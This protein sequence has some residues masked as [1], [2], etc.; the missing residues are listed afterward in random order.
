RPHKESRPK[1]LSPGSTRDQPRAFSG[2]GG[3]VTEDAIHLSFGD[4][5]THL[6]HRI[7]A[8]ADLQILHGVAQVVDSLLVDLLL[9]EETRAGRADLALVEKDPEERSRDRPRQVGVGED[10]VRRLAPQ[11]E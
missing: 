5:R 3:D 7:D 6:G 8:R 11:L 2:A 4:E 10:D 1:A 9:D